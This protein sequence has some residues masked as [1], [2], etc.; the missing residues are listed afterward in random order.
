MVIMG[1]GGVPSAFCSSGMGTKCATG[2][3]TDNSRYE[4]EEEGVDDGGTGRGTVSWLLWDMV[5]SAV[6]LEIGSSHTLSEI[7]AASVSS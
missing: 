7:S 4:E 2:T 6:R 5:F 1:R 3:G